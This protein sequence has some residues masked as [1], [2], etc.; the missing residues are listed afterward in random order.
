MKE[1]NVGYKNEEIIYEAKDEGR[2]KKSI[3]KDYN[4]DFTK[5]KPTSV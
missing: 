1:K 2:Y 4:G 5:D 3:L